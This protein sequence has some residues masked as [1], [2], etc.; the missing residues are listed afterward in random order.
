MCLSLNI[1]ICWTNED[2]IPSWL[3]HA[4]RIPSDVKQIKATQETNTDASKIHSPSDILMAMIDGFYG[5]TEATIS[6]NF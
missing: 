4:K 6:L 2:K 3:N 1:Q 5:C